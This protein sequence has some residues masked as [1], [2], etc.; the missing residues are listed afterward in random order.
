MLK[1]VDAVIFDLGGVILNL[2]YNLTIQAF[3]DLGKDDFDQLYQQAYQDKIF[4]Q[5]ECGEISS[6]EF[7]NYLK[8]FYSIAV[9]DDQIDHAWNVMLLD[10]PPQRI[11]LL[12]RISQTHRIFLFSN[13]N[14]IHYKAFGSG[15]ESTY[16]DPRLLETIFEKTYYSHLVGRR[17]PNANAFQLVL[18]ENELNANRTL[19]IDDSE[20]HIIGAEQLGLKT[21]WM[22]EGDIVDIFHGV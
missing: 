20:Q 16:G 11:E 5:Y 9:S 10:L 21:H 1:E 2:D 3:K 22:V 19:F 17:K 13:T 8:G 14:D 4:D 15:I 18:E 6:R 7:R 12:R